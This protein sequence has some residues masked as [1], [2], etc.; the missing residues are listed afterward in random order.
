MSYM[1]LIATLSNSVLIGAATSRFNEN[2][3]LI[4]IIIIIAYSILI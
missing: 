2:H 3:V 4:V 1:A